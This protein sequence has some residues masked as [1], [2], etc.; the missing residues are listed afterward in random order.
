MSVKVDKIDRAIVDLLIQHGRM[1][2]SEIARKIGKLTERAVRYRY[3]RLVN[4]GVIRV[5]AIANPRVLG[6]VVLA[7]VFVEVEPGRVLEVARKIADLEV[8]TYVGGST[9]DRDLS[10]QIVARDNQELYDLVANVIGKVRGVRRTTTLLLP[11]ILK[12]VYQWSIP[13]SLCREDT[14][15]RRKKR[16][17]RSAMRT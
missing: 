7:D 2:F 4:E 11:V 5:S 16:T 6:Y 8:V 14:A 10:V 13:A 12:D 15:T 17:A 9:G 1:S 3:E